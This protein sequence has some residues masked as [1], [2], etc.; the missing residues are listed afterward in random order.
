MDTAPLTAEDE[1]LIETITGTNERTFDPE[2]FDGGH[3]V[4]A[5]VRT[6]DGEIYEGVSLPTAV[7][8]ASVCGEPV[9]IGSAIADGYG[10]AEIHTCVAVSHPMPSHDA[11]EISVVPPCGVCREMLADYNEEMRVVVPV[12]DRLRV[13]SA[14]QLLPARTW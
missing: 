2:F 9:A 13:A 11:T 1:T 7:G 3:I 14:I 6:T 5:G 12:A 10:H 8:R 4:T